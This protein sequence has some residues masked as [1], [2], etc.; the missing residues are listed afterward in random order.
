M[1]VNAYANAFPREMRDTL[2]GLARPKFWYFKLH[3]NCSVCT[4]CMSM[5]LKHPP[6]VSRHFPNLSFKEVKTYELDLWVFRQSFAEIL[7]IFILWLGLLFT[8]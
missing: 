4:V 3:Y 2:E 7:P 6:D 5:M 8:V 1:L